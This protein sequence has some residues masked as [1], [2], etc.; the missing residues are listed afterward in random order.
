MKNNTSGLSH[1]VSSGQKVPKYAKELDGNRSD[2]IAVQSLI[3]FSIIK[4]GAL[5]E[6][7]YNKSSSA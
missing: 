1:V 4:S 3:N 2:P 5:K 7:L 6:I